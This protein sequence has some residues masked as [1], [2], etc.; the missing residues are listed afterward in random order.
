MILE[1]RI[2]NT[3]SGKMVSNLQKTTKCKFLIMRIFII[4]GTITYKKLLILF[5]F[6]FPPS[7]KWED[8]RKK[9]VTNWFSTRFLYPQK[10]SLLTY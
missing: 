4:F 7:K 10:Y 3:G 5:P 8:E 9:E 2:T 1:F 6:L